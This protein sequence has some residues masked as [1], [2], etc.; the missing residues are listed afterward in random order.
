MWFI[1]NSSIK[2]TFTTTE[3]FRVCLKIVDTEVLNISFKTLFI[4]TFW[5]PVRVHYRRFGR[6]LCLSWHNPQ[7]RETE[8]RVLHRGPTLDFFGSLPALGS[9]PSSAPSQWAIQSLYF[10]HN[11]VADYWKKNC[12][13]G[14]GSI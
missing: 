4:F 3:P 1:N 5:H 14:K 11:F 10:I 8:P 9:K 13:I 6:I 12:E 7:S 2:G